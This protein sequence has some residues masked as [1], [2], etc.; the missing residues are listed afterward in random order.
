MPL[1]G[2]LRV[3]FDAQRAVTNGSFR[4]VPGGVFE[5]EA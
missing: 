4:T 1:T 2:T 3:A 5:D